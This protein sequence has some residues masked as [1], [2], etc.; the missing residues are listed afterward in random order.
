MEAGGEEAKVNTH[1][2]NDGK[3]AKNIA[4]SRNTK[5]EMA[6]CS[7]KKA[8]DGNVWVPPHSF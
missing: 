2:S 1:S 4:D 6:K 5:M 3:E 8:N 7:T